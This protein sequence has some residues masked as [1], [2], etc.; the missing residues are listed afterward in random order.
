MRG[1]PASNLFAAGSIVGE[2]R[3]SVGDQKYFEINRFRLFFLI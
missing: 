1:E 3:L 2:L